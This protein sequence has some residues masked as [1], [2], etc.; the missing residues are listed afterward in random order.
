MRARV[1]CQLS[2]KEVAGF[3]FVTF[4][5]ESTPMTEQVHSALSENGRHWETLNDMK[6]V[7]VRDL[8]E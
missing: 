4:Q 8:C 5:S 1:S 7:L 6:P 2:A 3:L